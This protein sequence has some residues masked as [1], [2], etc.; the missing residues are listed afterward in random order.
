[1][2]LP[3]KSRFFTK[4]VSNGSLTI[5]DSMG[6]KALTATCTSATAGTVTGET[7]PAIGASTALTLSQN[8]TMTFSSPSEQNIITGL[9]ITAGAA[10]TIQVIIEF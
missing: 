10:C 1:M 4:T 8:Q 9:T 5:T 3:L 2:E 7:L 6:V